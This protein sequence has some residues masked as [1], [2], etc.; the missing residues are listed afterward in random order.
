MPQFT[1]QS[2]TSLL[3]DEVF[4]F[5]SNY[6]GRHGKGAALT[7]LRLFG[8]RYGQGRGHVGQSYAIPTKGLRLEPL[9]LSEI[10]A[11]AKEF[12]QYARDN[13]NLKFLLTEV[14]CGLA[15][16]NPAQ[17]ASLF[18][19]DI[20]PNVTIPESFAAAIYGTEKPGPK[21]A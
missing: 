7:A 19:P 14:G 13:P 6:A 21:T 16:Y 3:P 10:A 20:P 4:V 18:G 8:A 2:I 11:Y 17:I 15:G 9:P 5:G 12:I 1:P